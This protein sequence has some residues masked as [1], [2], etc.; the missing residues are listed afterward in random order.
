MYLLTLPLQERNYHIFYQLCKAFTQA[1]SLLVH[2]SPR[3]KLMASSMAACRGCMVHVLLRFK[4][5]LHSQSSNAS[6]RFQMKAIA[7]IKGIDQT[8]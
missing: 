4:E 2:D 3:G 7:N 8:H 6:T 1:A 5:V